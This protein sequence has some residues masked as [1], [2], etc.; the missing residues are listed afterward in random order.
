MF[1][2]ANS[3]SQLSITSKCGMLPLAAA[4]MIVAVAYAGHAAAADW[5]PEKNVEIVA[6]SGP[7]GANDVIARALQRIM[8]QMK[9]VEAP[10]T[11]VSKVGAGGVLGWTYLNQ[12]AG[13]GGYI[14]GKA[15]S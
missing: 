5:K 15:I 7:G 9:L 2:Y 13:D 14:S 3:M 1:T 8:Q 6:M 12:H 10:I 11:V 4:L